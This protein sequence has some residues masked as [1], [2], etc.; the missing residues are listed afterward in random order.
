MTATRSNTGQ[1]GSDRAQAGQASEAPDAELPAAS[2][3]AAFLRVHP[4]FLA[5][6]PDLYRVLDPPRRVHG[7]RM[8]DQLERAILIIG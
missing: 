1:P 7:E 2:A 3:V 4:E 5:E 6:H 8:A